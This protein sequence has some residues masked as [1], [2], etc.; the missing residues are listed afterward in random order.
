MVPVHIERIHTRERV[1]AECVEGLAADIRLIEL[2]DLVVYL[3]TGQFASVGALVQ[4]SL[5]LSF[6]PDT[7]IFAY[8]GDVQLGWAHQPQ[9]AL[10]LEFHDQGVHI[11]FRLIVRAE[12]SDVEILQMYFDNSS[13]SPDVNTLRMGE[14]LLRARRS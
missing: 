9:I 10:D 5:E 7:M 14:A 3:Q 4:A 2:P 6:K 1:L 11:Y 13:G 8:S 12:A